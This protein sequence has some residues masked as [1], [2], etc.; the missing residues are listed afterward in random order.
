MGR[1]TA[2]F[3]IGAQ[4]THQLEQVLTGPWAYVAALAGLFTVATVAC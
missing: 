2:L 3:A 1:G 4:N